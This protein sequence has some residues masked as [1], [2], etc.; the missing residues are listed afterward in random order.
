MYKS[1]SFLYATDTDTN[2]T[3]KNTKFI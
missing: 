1:F 3:Y 2:N